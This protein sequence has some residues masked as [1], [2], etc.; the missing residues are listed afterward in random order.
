MGDN[1]PKITDKVCVLYISLVLKD[2][3]TTI[4]SFPLQVYFDISQ[5]GT[6]LGRIEIGLFGQ[7]VPKTVKNFLEVS[8]FFCSFLIFLAHK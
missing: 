2:I 5:G 8:C 4:L 6:D 1:R 3:S 7:I